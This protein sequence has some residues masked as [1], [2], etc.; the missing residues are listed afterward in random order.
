MV[1]CDGICAR[2]LEQTG[3]TRSGLLLLACLPH[4]STRAAP[5][6]SSGSF[7]YRSVAVIRPLSLRTLSIVRL[8]H[9]SLAGPMHAGAARAAVVDAARDEEIGPVAMNWAGSQFGVVM[10]FFPK[11]KTCSVRQ[12]RTGGELAS[13]RPVRQGQ[14][15]IAQARRPLRKRL[16][17]LP[18]LCAKTAKNGDIACGKARQS[19]LFLRFGTGNR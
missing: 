18:P 17:P 15:C 14:P 6:T 3:R 5:E 19:R 10:T 7:E 12:A 8:I 4:T 9:M 16:S 11:T 2:R 13:F 1:D